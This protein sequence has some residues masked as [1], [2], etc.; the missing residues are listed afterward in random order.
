MDEK[1]QLILDFF[2]DCAPCAWSAVAVAL[3]AGALGPVVV[4]NRMAFF[5]DAI[6]HSSLL[7]VAI[8]LIAGLSHE[9]ELLPMLCVAVAL[10]LG[11]DW[12]RRRKSQNIDTLLGVAM[13]GA[14]ALGVIVYQSYRGYGDLHGYLFGDLM[15]M[16]SSWIWPIL[17]VVAVVFAVAVVTFNRL[18][19]LAV[20]REIAA[21]R[22]LRSAA[23]E[24]ALV[25]LLAVVVTLG[26]RTVGVLMVNALLVVPG[27]AA[28][29]FS[30]DLTGFFWT[31]VALSV[32][33]A[34]GGLALSIPTNWPP[35]PV[36]VCVAVG[37]FALSLLRKR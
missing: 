18:S 4:M 36:I 16:P 29:N 35:G 7:G 17:L 28:R 11:I 15:L 32:A 12:L 1:M 22:G 2:T 10:G 37:F 5:S 34:L 30:R 21:A 25:V 27:A 24:T 23:Y 20:S 31:S 3:A 8:G 26:V 14:L 13:A 6:A 33:S 19:L 9:V